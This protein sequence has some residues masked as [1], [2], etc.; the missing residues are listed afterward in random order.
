MDISLW[1]VCIQWKVGHKPKLRF[2]VIYTPMG[3]SGPHFE[4]IYHDD[5][6]YEG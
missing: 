6:V 1:G 3:S 2:I 5:M 4:V